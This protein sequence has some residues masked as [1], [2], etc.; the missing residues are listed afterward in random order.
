VARHGTIPD[1]AYPRTRSAFTDSGAV[2]HY[3]APHLSADHARDAYRM[4]MNLQVVAADLDPRHSQDYHR[5]Q[6]IN[7]L[8]HIAWTL[9]VVAALLVTLTAAPLADWWQ[10]TTNASGSSGR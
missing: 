9:V 1:S 7:R 6:Q 2:H 5:A 8:R 10:L 4:G 3:A